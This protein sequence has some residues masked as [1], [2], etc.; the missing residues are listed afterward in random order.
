[1]NDERILSVDEAYERDEEGKPAFNVV[2]VY[3]DRSAALR[4]MNVLN[5]LVHQF[6]DDFEFHCDLWRFDMLGLPRERE[7]AAH[8]GAAADLLIVSAACDTDLPGSARDWLDKSIDGKIPGSA[9]LVALLESRRR[10][11]NVQCRTRQFLQSAADRG[12]MD[13]FLHE[14][15]LPQTGPE[16]TPEVLQKRANIVSPVLQR[17]LLET[18]HCCPGGPRMDL[19][20]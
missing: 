2:I 18:S 6:G 12:L 13:L 20:S 4:A 9:A 11:S 1:M 15:D 10:L 14:V 17:I 19:I 8:A 7:A 3:D 5:G 16:W